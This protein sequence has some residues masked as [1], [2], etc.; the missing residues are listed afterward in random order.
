M[1]RKGGSGGFGRPKFWGPKTVLVSTYAF[2]L[3]CTRG[4]VL[5]CI[6]IWF[7]TSSL[8]D[9]QVH[10]SRCGRTCHIDLRSRWRT[11]IRCRFAAF[12]QPPCCLLVA[13]WRRVIQKPRRF[14]AV[15][16]KGL[17]FILSAVQVVLLATV[18]VG[19]VWLSRIFIDGLRRSD[20]KW[21]PEKGTDCVCVNMRG[22]ISQISQRSFAPLR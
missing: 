10:H 7:G 21:D 5:M 20:D 3:L 11:D 17:A 22:T 18:F 12:S 15:R 2:M 8:G 13:A 9:F 6:E 14:Q 4:C 16:L 1:P 19:L